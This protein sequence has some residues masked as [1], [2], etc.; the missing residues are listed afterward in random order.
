M[1]KHQGSNRSRIATLRMFGL[2][3]IATAA[4]ALLIVFYAFLL[5]LGILGLRALLRLF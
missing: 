5:W 1:M 4:V 3:L 2:T